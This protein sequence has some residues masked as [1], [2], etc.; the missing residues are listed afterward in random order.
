MTFDKKDTLEIIDL[1][2]DE[3]LEKNAYFL[4]PFSSEIEV[5]G[6]KI[7]TDTFSFVF[8]NHQSIIT[9]RW[10]YSSFYGEIEFDYFLRVNLLFY[11]EHSKFFC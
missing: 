1:F 10:D 5:T 9:D 6:K 8:E 3:K 7:E 2:K 4:I 11:N